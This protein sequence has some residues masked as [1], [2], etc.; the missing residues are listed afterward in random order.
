MRK[1]GDLELWGVQLRA[2]YDICTRFPAV[3]CMY[4]KIN[5]FTYLRGKVG[6][7]RQIARRHAQQPSAGFSTGRRQD[8]REREWWLDRWI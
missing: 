3:H 6:A 4:V 1:K 8:R 7:T 2:A 5:T